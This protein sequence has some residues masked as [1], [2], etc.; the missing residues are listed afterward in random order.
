LNTRPIDGLLEELGLGRP[1]C[2]NVLLVDDE[3]E[4]LAVLEALLEDD[5][6]VQTALGGEEAIK[7][8]HGEPPIDLVITDQRMPGMTGVE[9]LS[10]ISQQWPDIYRIVLTA[11]SDVDPIVGAIN[12]GSVDRFILKPWDP[13][14]L[15]KQVAAGIADREDRLAM[16]R[17]GQTLRERHL[18]MN[19]TLANLRDTQKKADASEGLAVLDWMSSGLTAELEQLLNAVGNGLQSLDLTEKDKVISSAA[20][21]ASEGLSRV[22]HLLDDMRRIQPHAA[23]AEPRQPTDLRKL[24]SEAIR[25]LMDEDLG[26]N[27]PIHV[28]LEANLGEVSLIRSYVRL[29]ILGLLR[30]AIRAS[31][32]NTPIV[33]RVRTER[34]GPTIIEVADQGVGMTVEVLQRAVQP[35]FSA[36]EP[37][38]NG[39]GLAICRMVAEAHGGRLSLLDNLP[40]GVLAQIWLAP[41]D[42]D[43]PIEESP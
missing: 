5:W 12:E 27:N 23:R 3:F 37:P 42:S 1:Q 38:G 36:F 32:P 30:N 19:R 17:V 13:Q 29:A 16:K 40:T 6:A 14:A 18:A 7:I 31:P 39:L 22:H 10:I 28:Q 34:D 21:L 4:V 35:F 15:R 2:R 25:L 11:Y 24:I 8:L 20:V 43:D 41:P 26:D 33:V 9:L